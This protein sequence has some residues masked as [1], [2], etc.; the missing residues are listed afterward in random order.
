MP[1][2]SSLWLAQPSLRGFSVG[3]T[4]ASLVLVQ[5]SLTVGMT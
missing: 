4:G 3:M 1:P 5:V 2:A